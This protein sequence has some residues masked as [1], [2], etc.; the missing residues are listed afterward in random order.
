VNSPMLSDIGSFG[1]DKGKKSKS[2][3]GGFLKSTYKADLMEN[4]TL[5]TKLE[6]FSNY[7]KNP[8]NINVNWEVLISMKVNKYIS[9]TLATQL[10]YDDNTMIKIDDTHS[11]PR[12]QF[13]EVFGVGFSYKF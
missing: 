2:E 6:L 3:F 12:V 8:Q 1:V 13:K 5:Q 10:L 7:L 11:G 9:A 4:V